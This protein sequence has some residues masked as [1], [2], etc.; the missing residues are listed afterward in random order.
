MKRHLTTG[1][2]FVPYTLLQDGLDRVDFQADTR[3]HLQ[4]ILGHK[5][6]EATLAYYTEINA[7]LGIASWVVCLANYKSKQ[8]KSLKKKEQ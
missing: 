3:P 6:V 1:P 5:R 2:T 8:L 7:N 4:R